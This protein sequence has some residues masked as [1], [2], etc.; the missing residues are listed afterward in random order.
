MKRLT[1]KSWQNLDT[2]ECCGQDRDC[3]ADCGKCVVPNLYARLAEYEDLEEQGKLI[4][5]PFKNREVYIIRGIT[6][7]EDILKLEVK[8]AVVH[9]RIEK[10]CLGELEVLIMD[11]RIFATREQAEAR[12]KELEGEYV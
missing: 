9:L 11:N 3:K 1:E 4:R 8:L 10:I 2:W 7:G 6:V 5:L 12:L